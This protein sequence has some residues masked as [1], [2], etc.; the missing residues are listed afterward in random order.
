MPPGALLAQQGVAMQ[1]SIMQF[2]G[3]APV[4]QGRTR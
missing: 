1:Q 4:T 3:H 2:I